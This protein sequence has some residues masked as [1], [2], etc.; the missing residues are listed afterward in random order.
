MKKN[1]TLKL[2]VLVAIAAFT[3]CKKSSVQP[4]P[5]PPK[6]DPVTPV[7]ATR[8]ELSL[9][10][11]FLYAKDVYYWNTNLPTYGDFNPRRFTSLSKD[12]DN[13]NA[14]LLE[15]AKYSNS[16]EYKTTSTAPKYSYIFD[17]TNK[18][19]TAF[20]SKDQLAVDLLGNGNDIGVRIV[21]YLTS[22]SNS[23]PYYP[24]ITAVYQGSPADLAGLKRGWYIS[25]INGQSYGANYSAESSSLNTAL[26]GTNVQLD[27]INYLTKA[28]K[29][30]TLTKAVYKS[31]PIYTKKIYDAGGKKIGYLNFARFSMLSTPGRNPSDTN[32]DPVFAEFAAAN[33]TDL[34]VDL[35][36]NGG[37][38]VSTAEYMINLIAPSA[39]NGKVMYTEYY[40]SKMQNKQATIMRNQPLLDINDKIQYVNGRIANYFD[41]ADYSTTANTAKFDKKGGLNTIQNV[42]FIVS[43]NTASASELVINSL[44]PYVNVKTVGATT[45]GKPIG[46]F[47]VTIENRYDVYFSMFET[48]NSLG[49]GGYFNGITPDYDEAN[50]SAYPNLWDDPTHDFGDVKEAYLDQALKVLAPSTTVQPIGA[51]LAGTEMMTNTMNK[52]SRTKITGKRNIGKGEFVGMVSSPRRKG[53]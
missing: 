51:K 10:S 18:N 30:V 8:K 14:E 11:I 42:V 24:F 2:F 6:P 45:Y 46:F 4:T 53:Q 49:Q 1:F 43:G 50:A 23:S 38:Y 39:L 22:N 13:Y 28:T 15:I 20:N 31:S 21:S 16:M 44:K 12:L 3:A 52:L 27:L 19:P 40:N 29:S 32:L 36:Y 17:R 37:G 5:E 41:D 7:T 9:D 47:P 33:V 25:K 26:S 35:R 34:I 48:K